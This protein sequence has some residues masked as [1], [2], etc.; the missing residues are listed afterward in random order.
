MAAVVDTDKCQGSA[1]CISVCPTEAI[2][3]EDDKAEVDLDL[4][5]D[6]GACE[7]ACPT[8]AITIVQ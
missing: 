8:G 3:I 6:C 7:Q 5:C 2:T 4:C 1:K